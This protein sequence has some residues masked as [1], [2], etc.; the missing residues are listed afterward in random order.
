ML[1]VH[2]TEARRT[3]VNLD[4][5]SM[6]IVLS[7]NKINFHSHSKTTYRPSEADTKGNKEAIRN[8]PPP[9][10]LKK[11]GTYFPGFLCSLGWSCNPVLGNEIKRRYS[12]KLSDKKDQMQLVLFPT[13]NTNLDGIPGSGGCH[14]TVMKYK[15]MRTKNQHMKQYD[16][17]LVF[18]A[19]L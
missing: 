14:F 6:L 7:G 19:C 13:L 5:S 8:L 4:R 15:N 11:W 17:I 1:P 12:G 2:Q 3:W 10:R 16:S 18:R 9:N